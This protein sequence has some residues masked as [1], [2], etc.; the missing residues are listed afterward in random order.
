MD[1]DTLPTVLPPPRLVLESPSPTKSALR[2][3]VSA[4]LFPSSAF[5]THNLATTQG[6]SQPSPARLIRPL[7]A[8]QSVSSVLSTTGVVERPKKRRKLGAMCAFTLLFP[9]LEL[10]PSPYSN[11]ANSI[12]LSRHRM[13]HNRLSRAKKGLLTYGFPVNR[14]SYSSSLFLLILTCLHPDILTRLTTLLPTLE[15]PATDAGLVEKA[16]G[17]APARHLAKYLFPRQ[18]GLH[19]P[20]TFAKPKSSFEVVPDYVVREL[21]IK[22]RSRSFFL[23]FAT[24]PTLL[25]RNSVQ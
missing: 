1:V 17:E 9:P 22:A 24:Y 18:F 14:P 11:S 21:E 10:T 16:R 20:F 13:Y 25:N 5:S 3:T 15:I 7:R 6:P 8:T 19:N 4:P 23:L 2:P 12:V